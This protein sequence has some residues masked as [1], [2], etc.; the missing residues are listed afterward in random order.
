MIR[1]VFRCIVG[2]QST[3]K[4]FRKVFRSSEGE[5]STKNDFKEF[6]FWLFL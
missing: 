2:E 3:K 6:K 5:Q 4:L 1:K